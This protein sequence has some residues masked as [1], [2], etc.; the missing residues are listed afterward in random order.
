M[1][2]HFIRGNHLNINAD[3]S[4]LRNLRLCQLT[5]NDT[6]VPCKEINRG[7][8][9]LAFFH[10]QHI[11]L[12]LAWPLY[13]AHGDPGRVDGLAARIIDHEL[14]CLSVAEDR[15]N[16]HPMLDFQVHIVTGY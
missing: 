9:L 15:K 4:F 5:R 6:S 13:Q 11:E 1:T 2:W 12:R 8:W 14:K 16:R 10:R 7:Y 3:E